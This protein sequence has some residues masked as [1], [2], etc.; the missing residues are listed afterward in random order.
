[1]IG[2]EKISSRGKDKRVK[3]IINNPD[4]LENG[5]SSPEPVQKKNKVDDEDDFDV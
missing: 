1:M 3:D 4:E 5:M 2:R